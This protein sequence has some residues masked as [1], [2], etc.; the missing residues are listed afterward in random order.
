MSYVVMSDSLASVSALSW[1]PDTRCEVGMHS[2]RDA[3]PLQ[4]T[5][6]AHIHNHSHVGTKYV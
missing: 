3:S 4:G 2:G 6:H 1:K 5:M